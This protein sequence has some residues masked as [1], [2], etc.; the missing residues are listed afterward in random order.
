MP[1]Q[2]IFTEERR[3]KILELLKE[4]NKVLVPQLC[5]T[6][7]VSQATIRTD[8]NV[9]EKQGL[10]QRTHGGAIINA[11]ASYERTYRQKEQLHFD[12]KA[13]IAE[14]AAELVND[15]D[16]I[17]IDTGTTTACMVPFL[18]KKSKL[19]VITTDIRIALALEH[20]PDISVIVAGGLLR[21]GF[22]CTIGAMTNR[23]LSMFNVDKAFMATNGLS[24]NGAL[25]TPYIEQAEVK[26]ALIETAKERILLCD[27]S[28]LG[29]ASLADFADLADFRYFITDREIDPVVSEKL[30]KK[31]HTEFITV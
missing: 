25:S 17:S 26:K 15:G 23:F 27:S 31:A 1:K 24:V 6:F 28:K 16:T 10:L 14:A 20:Y 21:S 9:L 18:A 5:K 7:S 4:K 8:L 30:R 13:R 2:P 22:S 29:Q 12:A 11:G 19:T 3:N